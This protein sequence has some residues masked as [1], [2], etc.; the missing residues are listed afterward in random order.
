MFVLTDVAEDHVYTVDGMWLPWV[1][2]HA[3]EVAK[4]T[5]QEEAE[6]VQFVLRWGKDCYTKVQEV[7]DV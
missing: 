2:R 3:P 4:F 7:S 6:R 5:T 1:H